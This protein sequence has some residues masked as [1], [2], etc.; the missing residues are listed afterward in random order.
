VLDVTTENSP[1][2]GK[3]FEQNGMRVYDVDFINAFIED[4]EMSSALIDA[5]HNSI[6]QDLE[7]ESNKLQLKSFKENQEILRERIRED[8]VT[9]Q[10]RAEAD[11]ATVDRVAS[12]SLKRV[13][14]LNIESNIKLEN[15]LAEQG[16]HEEIQ[17]AELDRNQANEDL[18]TRIARASLELRKDELAAQTNAEVKRLESITPQLVAAMDQL[19]K[20]EMVAKLTENLSPLAMLGGESVVDVA[21][22]LFG[23]TG[24]EKYVDLLS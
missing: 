16:L 17:K 7:L 10:L 14:S 13:E 3:V 4:A 23:G 24:L 18:K 5:Q 20:S 9:S 6:R 8:E 12:L 22:K 19:G 15:K 11:T 1:R 21:R 2:P